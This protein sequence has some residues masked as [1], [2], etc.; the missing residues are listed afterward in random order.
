MKRDIRKTIGA[1]N[2]GSRRSRH[3]MNVERLILDLLLNT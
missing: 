2:I 1:A 3:E